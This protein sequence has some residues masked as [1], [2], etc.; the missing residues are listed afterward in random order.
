MKLCHCDELTP[1]EYDILSS[2]YSSVSHRIGGI[3]VFIRDCESLNAPCLLTYTPHYPWFLS[4]RRRSS[5]LLPALL[6]PDIQSA[7]SF[8]NQS[9]EGDNSMRLRPKRWTVGYISMLMLLLFTLSNFALDYVDAQMHRLDSPTLYDALSMEVIMP[10][11]S[12]TKKSMDSERPKLGLGSAAIA[13][14]TEALSPIMPFMGG[15]DLRRQDL[16]DTNEGWFNTAYSVVDQVRD[17]FGFDP[18]ANNGAASLLAKIPRAGGTFSGQNK[19]KVTSS[20]TR[21][22]TKHVATLS[23]QTPF[24]PMDVIATMTLGDLTSIFEYVIHQNRESSSKSFQKMSSHL[25]PIIET[26]EAAIEKSRGKNVQPAHTGSCHAQGSTCDALS[27]SVGYGDLDALQ[28]CSAMRLFAEW[29]L[30]RQVPEGYKGY[31]VGMSLGHKDVVQNVAKIENAV[32]VWLDHQ[33]E[34][35]SLESQRRAS[36]GILDDDC[37]VSMILSTAEERKSSKCELRSPT[38]RDLL[39]YEIDMDTHSSLPRLK[40][41]TAAMGLLWVRRQLAYQTSIFT[42]ILNVPTTF[43]D[44]NSAVSAAYF[45]VYGKYH[46]WA[47]QK[48]FTYSFQ[49]APDVREIY[50]FMNPSHLN[51]V[52]SVA[53]KMSPTNSEITETASTLYLSDDK[54]DSRSEDLNPVEQLGKHIGGE[55]DKFVG[56]VGSIFAEKDDSVNDIHV[57][58]GGQAQGLQGEELESFV[59]EKMT[60]NAHEHILDYLKAANPLLRDLAGLFENLNMEDPTKV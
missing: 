55:W 53:R 33:R 59:M 48:I 18:L 49:A 15:L 40:D 32:H 58:G 14:I 43:P 7:E 44:S 52:R 46:G 34:L 45:E 57:R 27:P 19:I 17:A 12:Y 29:R 28:F 13:S 47:V 5:A 50:K 6:Q 11:F 21:R 24:V 30:V 10:P 39:E 23:A 36:E 2:A 20:G 60:E 41:K 9:T 54:S 4:D 8:E 51:H 56:F 3:V 37:N 22:T 16:W 26:M 42:N 35:K 25:K 31:A 38:L 1:I